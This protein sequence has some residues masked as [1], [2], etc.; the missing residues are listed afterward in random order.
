M[1]LLAPVIWWKCLFNKTPA[2]L[3]SSLLSVREAS[4][5]IKPEM[6]GFGFF[7]PYTQK[8][9]FRCISEPCFDQETGCQSDH[10]NFQK[11]L[12][13][14]SK[15]TGEKTVS[16]RKF[17]PSFVPSD[18]S[19]KPGFAKQIPPAMAGVCSSFF[20]VLAFHLCCSLTRLSEQCQKGP[21]VTKTAAVNN[22]Q[23]L[24]SLFLLRLV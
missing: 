12:H 2:N 4:F 13:C 10:W 9:F 22:I 16:F 21:H 20:P 8:I 23:P 15:E 18:S 6:F 5:W 3:C 17:I 19:S 14:F 7:F 11:A 1:S 24:I